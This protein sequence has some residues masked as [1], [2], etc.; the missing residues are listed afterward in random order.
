ML[1]IL[2]NTIPFFFTGFE[3]DTL[4]VNVIAERESI[5]TAMKSPENRNAN[6]SQFV[7]PL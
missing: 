6:E 4:P 3:R 1:R 7:R 2:K 5:W